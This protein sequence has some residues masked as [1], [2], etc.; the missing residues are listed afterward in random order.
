M[1]M[2]KHSV[3]LLQVLEKIAG[4][5]FFDPSKLEALVEK[6]DTLE[7]ELNCSKKLEKIKSL[8]Y[9]HFPF[10]EDVNEPNL[11]YATLFFIGCKISRY[12][13]DMRLRYTINPPRAWITDIR[14]GSEKNFLPFNEIA[15]SKGM[16]VKDIDVKIY[17]LKNFEEIKT[18]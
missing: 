12:G 16:K 5:T 3:M 8:I 7:Q 2:D 17:D 15:Q 1:T 18:T 9:D 6:L 13:N 11:K 4:M 14:H 10:N